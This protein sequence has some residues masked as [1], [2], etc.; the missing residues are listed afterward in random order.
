MDCKGLFGG[1]K[2]MYVISLARWRR[3]FG[4]WV[5]TFLIAVAVLVV[6]FTVYRFFWPIA[7]VGGPLH[8]DVFQANLEGEG[9]STVHAERFAQ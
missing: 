4:P 1:V 7:P 9:E 8:P 5:R 6:L 2:L 3:R